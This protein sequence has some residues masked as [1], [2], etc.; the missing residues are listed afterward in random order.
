M[1]VVDLLLYHTRKSRCN[2]PSP[3]LRPGAG[4]ACSKRR[5][6]E[7]GR[8]SKEPGRLQLDRGAGEGAGAGGEQQSE[9][10]CLASR[11]DRGETALILACSEGHAE[12]ACYLCRRMTVKDVIKLDNFGRSALWVAAKRG[13]AGGGLVVS[14]LHAA[15]GS[16]AQTNQHGE[17]PLWTAARHGHLQTV[18]C[19]CDLR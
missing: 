2:S 10:I 4:T 5:E 14:A 11:N 16:L 7:R 17:T 13:G 8:S 15:G 6:G 19:L 12:L 9:M 3:T 18:R 1:D